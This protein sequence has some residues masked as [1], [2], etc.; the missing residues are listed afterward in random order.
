[1]TDTLTKPQARQVAKKLDS[2]GYHAIEIVEEYPDGTM[3][4]VAMNRAWMK[5]TISTMAE[6]DEY[7]KDQELHNY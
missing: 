5:R 1:M 3:R 6:F 2:W 4:V 7:K